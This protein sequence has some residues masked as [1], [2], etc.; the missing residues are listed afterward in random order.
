MRAAVPRF[1]T[2]D[3]LRGLSILAVVLLHCWI[4]F[5]GSGVLMGAGLPPWSRRLLLHNGGNG[6]TVFFAVSGFL[7]TL[8]SVRRFGGLPA[9][10]AGQF[11]RIRFAR[12][13]PPLLLV[14]A[15]LSLLHWGSLHFYAL[16]PWY[17]KKA[18]G[19]LQALFA[20]LTFRLNRLE[21]RT[22]YL[23]ANWDVL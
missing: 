16:D 13:G 4:R 1:E 21:A 11:Y 20:A 22:G 12:I 23:P 18:V 19:L 17:V 7:I 10:R 15:M 3:L 14:L 9:M 2:V 6:V 8:T 5:V